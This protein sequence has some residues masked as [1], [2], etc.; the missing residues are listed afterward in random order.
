MQ[1]SEMYFYDDVY[2][3]EMDADVV[4]YGSDEKFG[5]FLVF[6]RTIFHPHGGGQKGDRG[7]VFFHEQPFGECPSELNITDTRGEKGGTIRHIIDRNLGDE[8]MLKLPGTKVTLQLN[9]DFRY[10]Q[11]RLHSSS[12]LIHIFMER[13]VGRTL[14][15]PRIS[16]I[17]EDY[18]LNVYET[19]LDI[20]P[21]DMP[22]VVSNMNEFLAAGHEITTYPDP[23]PQKPTYRY[24]K[25]EDVVI[26][27]GGTHPHS[28]SEVGPISATLSTKKGKT[29]VQFRLA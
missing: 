12:H 27:C 2:A 4:E 1:P 16:D 28:T 3:R 25:C 21:E 7:R 13:L 14:P 8:A 10:T 5:P 11:M 20:K 19:V 26:P 9:W 15:P 22:K 24:W 18:G 17:L 6:N 29:K 23:D